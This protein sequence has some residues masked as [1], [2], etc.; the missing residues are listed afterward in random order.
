MNTKIAMSQTHP[1]AQFSDPKQ[2]Q[3]L[4]YVATH[5]PERL[6]LF[7]RIYSG[8]VSPRQC[9]K[10]MCLECPGWD[11]MAID[12]CALTVCPFWRIRPF[13]S[14]AL[15]QECDGD[16]NESQR[17][18]PPIRPLGEFLAQMKQKRADGHP[19]HFLPSEDGFN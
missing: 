6:T 4:E 9:V 16:D 5:H 17:A 19:G 11:E 10:A 14:G 12:R 7:E 3:R 15:V 2:R 18:L 1:V 8:K 13:Q